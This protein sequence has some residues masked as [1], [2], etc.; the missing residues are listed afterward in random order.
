MIFLIFLFFYFFDGP[1]FF[2][3]MSPPTIPIIYLI[4]SSIRTNYPL[5]LNNVSPD[6]GFS[7]FSVL[8]PIIGYSLISRGSLSARSRRLIRSTL[9]L[10]G[11]PAKYH[12]CDRGFYIYFNVRSVQWRLS[13]D[14]LR[15]ILFLQETGLAPIMRLSPPSQVVLLVQ[16]IP[17][18]QHLSN[19]LHYIRVI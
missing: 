13:L 2:W 6:R 4:D 11:T 8:V 17:S 9:F 15:L 5:K 10:G 16:L 19:D 1:I 7:H 3:R 12:L 14:W 18:L